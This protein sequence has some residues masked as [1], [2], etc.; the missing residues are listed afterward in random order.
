MSIG[1][2]YLIAD[3]LRLIVVSNKDKY[4]LPKRGFYLAERIDI[5]AESRSAKRLFNYIATNVRLKDIRDF[6]AAIGLLVIFHYSD[7]Y[8][9]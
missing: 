8:S 7:Q 3:P 9:G 1:A 2:R 4:T 5:P 6:D